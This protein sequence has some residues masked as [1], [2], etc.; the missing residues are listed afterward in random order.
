MFR[1]SAGLTI[2]LLLIILGIFAAVALT[3][4]VSQAATRAYH[5]QSIDVDIR[6]LENS[7]LLVTERLT[8]AFTSGDFH[9]GYRWIPTDR[10]ESIDDV[11]VREGERKYELNPQVRQWIDIR[12][13]K[14]GSPGGDSYAYTTW[15]YKNQ[16]WI[17][18]WFPKTTNVIR[19]SVP[20]YVM[21]AARRVVDEPTVEF[22][23]AG[24]C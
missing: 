10:L 21:P 17:A 2:R 19:I 23:L 3:T 14:G 18:W 20:S 9:Y 15:V 1:R 22:P 5:Y 4:G 16:F 6:I 11:E 8:F 24:W 12:R 13:E 7:D